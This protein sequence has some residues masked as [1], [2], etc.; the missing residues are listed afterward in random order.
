[1]SGEKIEPHDASGVVK[2]V[3]LGSFTALVAVNVWTAAA[4]LSVW[5]GSKVQGSYTSLSLGAVALV[6]VVLTIVEI[7]LLKIL[8]WANARYDQ[9][10]G[11]PPQ[12]P[13]YPWRTSF[14][15]EEA[16]VVA[17]R[18][19]L[20]AVERIVALSVV[21]GALVFEFWFF[22]LASSSLPNGPLER[23]PRH[24]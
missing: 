17:Q 22:F 3:G 2:R 4:L 21:T 12:R 20:S 10:I 9:L 15:D 18:R 8:T 1:M 13:R 5:V 24:P 14:R 7:G 23:L 11:R 6:V 19:G 16:K